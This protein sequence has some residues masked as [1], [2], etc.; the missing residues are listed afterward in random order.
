[1]AKLSY[2][3][4]IEKHRQELSDFPI[5][6]AFSDEQLK[7]ALIKLEANDISECVT[8]FNHGDIVKKENAPKLINMFKNH[9][10]EIRDALLSDEE[11]AEAAFL[12]EMD[13][14]EYAINWDGDDDVLAC[15][16]LE[17]DELSE[18]GLES[19]YL[20]AANKHHKKMIE[21]GVI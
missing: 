6:Y 14:H 5:A 8:V 7:E 9:R 2:E 16:G 4:L 19:A 12:Y 10:K 13:N 21:W 11:F 18:L 20:R 15:F 3:K 1:M 17:F